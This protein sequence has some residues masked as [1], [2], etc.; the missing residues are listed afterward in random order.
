MTDWVLDRAIKQFNIEKFFRNNLKDVKC[1]GD[2]IEALCIA[3]EDHEL[4][5]NIPKKQGQCFSCGFGF[6][7]I[8]LIA[9]R[10]GWN[11]FAAKQYILKNTVMILDRDLT[12]FDADSK[13]VVTFGDLKSVPLPEHF[14]S[15]YN[16]KSLS[17][18]RAVNYLVRRGI[19]KCKWKDYNIG[20]GVDGDYMDMI[21]FPVTWKNMQ[22][23]FTTRSY[24]GKKYRNAPKEDGYHSKDTV[25][26]GFDQL[27]KELGFACIGEGPFDVLSLPN[28]VC[29]L[30]KTWSNLQLDLLGM[31]GITC[32]YVCLDS[33]AKKK[34]LDLCDRLSSNFDVFLTTF[35]DGTDPNDNIG[36]IEKYLEQSK[37][38]GGRASF[39]HDW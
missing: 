23:Y 37:E 9:K 18:G 2:E 8:S 27:D 19:E 1:N 29:S 16:N 7:L 32:V 3:C 5:M 20:Y 24:V 28:G 14:R 35:P 11:F 25:I 21:I 36:D 33:D 15:L 34:A 17:C 26:L 4:S 13:S 12:V 22:V 6:N 38:Y 39:L 31:S 30:G 10:F